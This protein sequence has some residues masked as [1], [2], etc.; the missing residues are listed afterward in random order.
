MREMISEL[1]LERKQELAG[2]RRG[3]QKEIIKKTQRPTVVW[4]PEQTL[5]SMSFKAS[6]E[7][8]GEPV[9]AH[10]QLQPL[11]ISLLTDATF[12]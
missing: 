10:V 5:L 6:L 7:A 8:P 4:K 11:L 12:L 9:S 1:T 2:K 3:L